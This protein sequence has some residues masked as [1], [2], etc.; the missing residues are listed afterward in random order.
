[1][2][3]VTS[4]GFKNLIVFQMFPFFRIFYNADIIVV[5]GNVRHILLAMFSTLAKI[6]N[7]KVIIWSV[8]HSRNNH[9]FMGGLRLKWWNFFDFFYLYNNKDKQNLE[10][11]GFKDKIIVSANNGLDQSYIESC[12]RNWTKQKLHSFKLK[13]NLLDKKIGI[14]IGRVID[15]RFDFILESLKL[16]IDQVPNFKW[17]LIG[18]GSNLLKLQT[19][20]AELELNNHVLFVGPLYDENQLAPYFLS[21][22]L[23]IYSED[24][25]LS[26]L[27]AFG[28]GLP[29]ITHDNHMYHGPE[30][31][32]FQNTITGELYEKGNSRDFADKVGYS[33]KKGYDVSTILSIVRDKYNTAMMY[34]NFMSLIKQMN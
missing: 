14:T 33:L 5:D 8:A 23:F 22:E 7:K 30:F 19:R 17:V 16:I 6:F 2:I 27:H 34:E 11:L 24:I 32:A 12:K 21:S 4:F 26:L 3:P 25:G 28:Y 20:C 13:N 18:D 15:S 10:E 1:M 31:C 9:Q 29:V